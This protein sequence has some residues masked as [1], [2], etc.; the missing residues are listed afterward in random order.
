MSTVSNWLSLSTDYLPKTLNEREVTT[1]EI[2]IGL[3][4][5]DNFPLGPAVCHIAVYRRTVYNCLDG[6]ISEQ[7]ADAHLA[8]GLHCTELH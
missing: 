6:I 5:G 2:R 8:I 1:Q 4:I 7:H 3:K